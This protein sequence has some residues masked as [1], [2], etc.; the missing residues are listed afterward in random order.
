QLQPY[1]VRTIC[2]GD[3]RLLFALLL[4][5]SKS[6]PTNVKVHRRLAGGL[7]YDCIIILS[8]ENPQQ[9]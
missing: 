2:P 5:Q 7:S 8:K 9:I 4:F 1:I 6:P 3:V